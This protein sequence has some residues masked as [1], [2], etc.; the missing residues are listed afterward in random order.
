MNGFV[1]L[2][3]L[4]LWSFTEAIGIAEWYEPIVLKGTGLNATCPPDVESQMALAKIEAET[5]ALLDAIIHNLN[6]SQNR[7]SGC[8]GVGW[9]NV[10]YINMDNPSHHCPQTVHMVHPL[11]I[12]AFGESV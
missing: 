3:L 2:L 5:D 1:Q 8:E 4:A 7:N 11:D 9:T 12:D 6:Q 10:A